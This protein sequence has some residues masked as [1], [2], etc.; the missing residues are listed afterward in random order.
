MKAAYLFFIALCFLLLRGDSYA[1]ARAHHNAL[2]YS[3]AQHTDKQNQIKAAVKNQ[4][5]TVVTSASSKEVNDYLI[6]V[7]DDDENTVFARKFMLPAKY[8]IILSYI[9][10]LS[11]FY[12]YVK[13]RLPFCIHLSYIDSCKYLV[14]RSLRI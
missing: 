8:F 2:C 1:Y 5:G 13:K 9:L 3:P 10:V 14:Q 6:S 7:E 12:T 4:D 11:T